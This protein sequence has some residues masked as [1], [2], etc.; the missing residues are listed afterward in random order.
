MQNIGFLDQ[1]VQA[2]MTREAQ[3]VIAQYTLIV[4]YTPSKLAWCQKVSTCRN[5]G[6]KITQIQNISLLHQTGWM[7][8]G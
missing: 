7:S 1:T 3:T 4:Q 8:V 5:K 2:Y 6:L